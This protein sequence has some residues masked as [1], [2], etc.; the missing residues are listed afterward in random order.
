MNPGRTTRTSPRALA[1]LAAVLSTLASGC[2]RPFE[3][4]TPAGFVELDNQEP[5]YDYRAT[6]ADGV[7]VAVRAIDAK[8][9]R[10][11]AFWEEAVTL[12]MR[13]VSGYALLE[14]KDV[15]SLDGTP[16]RELRFGHDQNGKAYLYRVALFTAQDRL[17][18]LE[19]GGARAAVE[20]RRAELDGSIASFRAR[21]GFFL[22]P[23]LA[24]RTCNRW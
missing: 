20:R 11:L 18:V 23:V 8:G 21:C 15:R 6:T 14:R 16:G 22:A 1:A 24:S 3:V 7:V 12:E 5:A 2:G 10:D 13:D 19:A 17:F 9:R 4:E